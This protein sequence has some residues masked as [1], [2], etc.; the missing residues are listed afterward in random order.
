MAKWPLRKGVMCVMTDGMSSM[1]AVYVCDNT[2]RLRASQQTTSSKMP[3]VK[4]ADVITAM[5]ISVYSNTHVLNC[6]YTTDKIIYCSL[7]FWRRNYFF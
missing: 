1:S 4:V 2:L 7:T 5:Y 6:M 3:A